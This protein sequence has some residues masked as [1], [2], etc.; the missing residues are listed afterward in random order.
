MKFSAYNGLTNGNH[1]QSRHGY[2]AA[3]YPYNA[4]KHH[5]VSHAGIHDADMLHPAI[6]NAIFFFKNGSSR[7]IYTIDL[8]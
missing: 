6:E 1:A 4:Q 8:I 3:S 2:D 5:I 7:P